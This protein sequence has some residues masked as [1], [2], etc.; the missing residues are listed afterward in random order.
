M[1]SIVFFLLCLVGLSFVSCGD[2]NSVA[3]K[4]T[5]EN[6]DSLFTAYKK[7]G[8]EVPMDV[9]IM[10][11]NALLERYEYANALKDGAEAYRREPKNLEARLLYAKCLNNRPNRTNSDL[12]AAQKH[13][14]FVLK[15]KPKDL[16]LLVQL[17]AV[18]AQI[19]D[20][21]KAFMYCNRALRI[22]KHYR[23]A[24][25]LKGKVYEELGNVDRAISSM[26]T[27]IQQDPKYF[28]AY[29]YVGDIYQ[30]VKNDPIAIEYFVSADQIRPNDMEIMYKLAYAYQTFNRDE[31]ALAVYRKM[32]K[33]DPN[34]TVST[35]QQGWIKQF[36]QNQPDSAILFYDITLQKE[37]R[38][39]EAWHNLG[40]VYEEAKKD[41]YEAIK[42][43]KMALKYDKDFELSKQA[44]DRLVK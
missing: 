3:V 29:L 33:K 31:E 26:E 21:D 27:A 20:A 8:K 44:M 15:K 1:K 2:G 10:H 14:E 12:V 13:F 24:Y 17:A 19:G 41:K 7:S 40:L 32:Q 5:T 38:Y 39:V 43:Y 16:E 35:F 11:G 4:A 36:H 18:H 28:P 34:F 30:N 25:I 22:D 9:L 42:C 37:P 6:V 23:D